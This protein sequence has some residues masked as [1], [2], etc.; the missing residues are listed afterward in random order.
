[1]ITF[2][3]ILQHQMQAVTLVDHRKPGHRKVLSLFL[4]DPN[5]RVI[6]T[7]NVPCQEKEVWEEA[8]IRDDGPLSK[9]PME[10]RRLVTESSK[11]FPISREEAEE[12]RGR[13]QEERRR[14]DEAYDGHIQSVE[15]G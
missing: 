11:S 7:A 8:L 9:F 15:S 4:V 3:N 6:S 14:Y 13:V 10:L 1:M 5:I 2:P 12:I